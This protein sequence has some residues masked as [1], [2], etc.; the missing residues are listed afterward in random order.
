MSIEIVPATIIDLDSVF[1]I[2]KQLAVRTKCFLLDR[3]WWIKKQLT[4][5]DNFYVLKEDGVVKGAICIEPNMIVSI[6]IRKQDQLQGHGTK[7]I[8][9]AVSKL[10]GK[11][12]TSAYCKYK[13]KDFFLKC[14]FELTGKIKDKP[15]AY[16]F[17]YTRQLAMW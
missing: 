1:E 16:N 5:T 10:Q 15:S 8:E 9:F 13:V 7:L 4:Q 6:A 17:L 3:K 2:H 12:V 14:G 11:I